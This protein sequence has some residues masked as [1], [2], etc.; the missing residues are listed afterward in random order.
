[1][2]LRIKK[3]VW[4]DYGV[5][6][7]YKYQVTCAEVISFQVTRHFFQVPETTYKY[8]NCHSPNKLIT[9]LKNNEDI[10]FH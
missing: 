8:Q 6:E 10:N 9:D 1:M 7:L 2:I 4:L 3:M 5:M